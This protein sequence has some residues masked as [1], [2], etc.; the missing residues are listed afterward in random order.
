MSASGPTQ[1]IDWEARF[2]RGETPWERP[3]QNPAFLAWRASAV[4]MPGR[5]L[6]PGAGRSS[7]PAALAEAGFAVTVVDG[8]PSAV[9][10]Q[11]ARLAGL[12]AEVVETDLFDWQPAEKF[13]AIY[14]QTCLCAL[15]PPMWRDYA[16]RL[17]EW[18]RP[19]GVLAIL[20]MQTGRDG[21][22]PF[23]CDLATMRGLFAAERWTWPDALPA[24]VAHPNGLHEQPA[25]LL[26]R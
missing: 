26:R 21:G 22:P 15:P 25:A 3:A 2:G 13:D 14:D 8:A 12:G 20:F 18:L 1:A 6:V 16:D 11:R 5:I 23:H 4:L 19:G 24:Q 10:Y 9:A 7:E 17:A